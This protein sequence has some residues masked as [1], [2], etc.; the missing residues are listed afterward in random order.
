MTVAA[1]LVAALTTIIGFAAL[2]VADHPS[3]VSVGTTTVVGVAAG[4]VA[5]LVL[6]PLLGRPVAPT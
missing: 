6:V 4:L 3:L 5:A 1:V 2:T